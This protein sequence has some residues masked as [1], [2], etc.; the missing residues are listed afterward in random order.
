MQARIIV[1][2][3]VAFGVVSFVAAKP[4]HAV[5]AHTASAIPVPFCNPDENLCDPGGK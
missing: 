4:S 3:A 2:L 5:K 1:A